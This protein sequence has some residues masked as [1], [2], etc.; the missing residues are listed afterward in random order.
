MSSHLFCLE[1]PF[2]HQSSPNFAKSGKM[3]A[4]GIWIIG[5][6]TNP[7][8]VKELRDVEREL[9]KWEEMAEAFDQGVRRGPSATR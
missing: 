2:F 7:P 5:Q 3:M 6:V 1:A 4:R 9:T 8:K